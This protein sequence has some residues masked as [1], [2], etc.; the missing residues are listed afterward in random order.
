QPFSCALNP[1]LFMGQDTRLFHAMLRRG[2]CLAPS[3]FET[4]LVSSARDQS[5]LEV[6]YEAFKEIS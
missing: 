6:T 2:V 5:T 4:M 3:A 1:H